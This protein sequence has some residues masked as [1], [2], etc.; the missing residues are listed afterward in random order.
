MPVLPGSRLP[1]AP[2][3]AAAGGGVTDLGALAE[4][5]AALLFVYKADCP[6]SPM[7]AAILPRFA[8]IPGLAVAAISQ[9]SPA[10]AARF[11]REHGWPIEVRELVDPE[12]WQASDALEI[13]TTPT[14]ILVAPGGRVEAESEGWSR[15][16]ANRLAALAA[17][18]TGAAPVVVARP[19]DGGP[20]FR[21][22]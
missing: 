3:Q 21:P 8:A 11:A 19:E 2:L 15:D 13:R 9:D 22:G 1:A 10:D 7:G 4:G 12:P 20:V 16:E 17:V 6:A 5:G 18:L 14:W